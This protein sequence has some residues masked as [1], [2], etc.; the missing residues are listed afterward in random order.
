MNEF[1]DMVKKE[2]VERLKDRIGQS[3]YACDLGFSLTDGENANGSWY[4]SAYKAK[5]DIKKYFDDYLNFSTYWHANYGEPIYFE[6]DPDDYHNSVECIHC[7]MMI[8]AI[9][10]VYNQAFAKQSNYDWN[11][12]FEITEEFIEEISKDLEEVEEVW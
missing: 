11:A 2:V 5:E 9:E 3:Y 6:E 8:S 12:E 10:S 4:C 1:L 7:C